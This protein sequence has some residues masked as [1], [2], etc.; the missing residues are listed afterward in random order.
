MRHV[1][2]VGLEQRFADDLAIGISIYD[3]DKYPDQTIKRMIEIGTRLR[4][5]CGAETVIMGCARMVRFRSQL[6]EAIGIPVIEACQAA[7][8]AALGAARLGCA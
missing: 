1:R 5:E 3:L 6:Q 4:D 2:E 7:V 8:T